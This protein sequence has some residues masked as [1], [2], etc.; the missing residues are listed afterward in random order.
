[1]LKLKLAFLFVN[2]FLIRTARF[3]VTFKADQPHAA[4][5][6]LHVLHHCAPGRKLSDV[7]A[8]IAGRGVNLARHTQIIEILS[9]PTGLEAVALHFTVQ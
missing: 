8:M 5:A 2:K 1:L 9:N 4:T 6:N 7:L 3:S